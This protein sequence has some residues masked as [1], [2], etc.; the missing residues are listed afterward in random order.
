[1]DTTPFEYQA[2]PSPALS[3]NAIEMTEYPASKLD[4]DGAFYTVLNMNSISV[5]ARNI[6][7]VNEDGSVDNRF[8][9]TE[10][11]DA[12][13]LT[14]ANET[15]REFK[16]R[17]R[18]LFR[19]G[20]NSDAMFPIVDIYRTTFAGKFFEHNK[21]GGI[22]RVYDVSVLKANGER[23]LAVNYMKHLPDR[24]DVLEANVIHTRPAHE[25][26]GNRRFTEILEK[27]LP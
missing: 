7:F 1:M 27:H 23:M 22:Y 26:F 24:P 3:L 11:V 18:F 16:D 6:P 12:I 8:H 10:S 2:T 14:I 17:L 20:E 19:T 15:K 21:T 4:E 5:L 9:L 13:D 25:F